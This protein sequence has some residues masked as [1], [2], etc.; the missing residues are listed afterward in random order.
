MR[1]I[2]YLVAICLITSACNSQT[3]ESEAYDRVSNT[4]WHAALSEADV[5]PQIIDVR[6][7]GEFDQGNIEGSINIDFLEDGFIEKMNAV[8][9][10][11][12]I[13]YIYCKSG[14]RSGKAAKQLEAEGYLHIIELEDGYSGYDKK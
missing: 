6:T 1:T 10:K 12:E 4:E 5:N 2:L 13:I 3:A 14:G 8:L 7:P 11:E 9:N